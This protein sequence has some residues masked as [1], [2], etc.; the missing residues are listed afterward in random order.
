VAERKNSRGDEENGDVV[1]ENLNKTNPHGKGGEV[2]LGGL[3]NFL[4][5]PMYKFLMA[6]FLFM[7]LF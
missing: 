7:V 5:W 2:E 1:L 6:T 4:N 3:I